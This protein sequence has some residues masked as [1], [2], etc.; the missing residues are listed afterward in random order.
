M[1]RQKSVSCEGVFWK[2]KNRGRRKSRVCRKEG[3]EMWQLIK[4]EMQKIWNKKEVWACLVSMMVMECVM[5]INWIYPGH[6][7]VQYCQNGKIVVYEGAKGIQEDQAL[8]EKYAGNLTDERVQRILSECAMP[9]E[10]MRAAGLEPAMEG[11]YTH[12][13]LYS[14]LRSF[15]GQD[16]KW[17]GMTVE[18]VYGDLGEELMLG[19]T[20]GWTQLLY[21]ISLT[22]LSLGCVLTIVLAPLF[23]EEYTRGMDALI[24]TGVQGRTQCAW[25]KIITGF[26][27]SLGLTGVTVLGFF[28]VYLGCYGLDGLEASIQI[29]PTNG[30]FGEMEYPMTCGQGVL[31]ALLM[32]F[33]ASVVL[34]AVSIFV[35]SRAK[36]SFN[37]LILSFV[38][39]TLPM[40]IPWKYLGILNL[41]AQF[42]PVRQMQ[43]NDIFE[44]P[45][46]QAGGMQLNL[47]WLS[48]PV[49]GAAAILCSLGARRTFARHQVE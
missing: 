19:Y 9:E 11:M 21:G 29:N 7:G 12:N 4:F 42:L 48:I 35:S 24:L 15:Y 45:L 44:C 33:T 28:L 49:A 3:D 46:L 8:A 43:L 40:F 13:S 25:A 10:D 6:N 20:A 23:A 39:F 17:N 38:F 16:G 5:I 36:S 41:P 18:E 37:G 30:L 1:S 34:A 2:G 22:L 26:L 32:W 31:F 47:M 27:V 14:S